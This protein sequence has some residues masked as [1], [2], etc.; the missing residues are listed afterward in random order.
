MNLNS[1]GTIDL[2][3]SQG[4]LSFCHEFVV[5]EVDDLKGILGIDYLV[6]HNVT[7]QVA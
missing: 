1:L 5:A 6:Q 7:I 3:I 2:Q 4:N